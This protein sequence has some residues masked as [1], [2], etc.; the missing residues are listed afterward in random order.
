MEEDSVDRRYFE[1]LSP[2]LRDVFS[3]VFRQ[4]GVFFG[5]FLAVF[6]SVMLYTMFAPGYQAHM[7]VL[8][9]RG[10]ADPLMTPQA[11]A[12]TEFQRNDITEEELNSE[13]ELLRDEEMLR[14]VVEAT[15]L[16]ENNS[17]HIFQRDDQNVRVAHAVR[18]MGRHLKA[19]PIRKTNLIAVSYDSGDPALAARVLNNLAVAYVEKH[20]EVHRPSGEF[21]FFEQ[22]TVDYGRRLQEAEFQLLDFTRDQGVVSAALERDIALQ[23]L[24]EAEVNSLQLRLA[25]AETEHR[26][27]T[28]Q[29]DMPSIPERTTTQVRIADN[30]QLLEKLKS[31]LLE[32]QLNRTGL[33]TKY[34]PS[35]RL[36]Q[37]VEQQIA[38]TRQSIAAERLTP[39]REETTEKDLN[40]E[41]VRQ[42]TEKA[43]VELSGLRARA[44]LDERQLAHSRR[45]A[46][47]LGQDAITQQDLLRTM[48]AAEENYLLYVRKREEARIGDALDE[49]GILNVIVAEPPTVPALPKH[50]LLTVALAGVVL[51]GLLST[52]VSF[53]RDYLDPAFR[54]P[55]EV[56]ACLRTP[57]LASLPREVA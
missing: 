11:N 45:Q 38:E 54:T 18:R 47:Q 17:F 22:Q 35:Y 16:A 50:S 26:M 43:S 27:R 6:L 57:V 39:T 10:R 24:S 56:V 12:P 19:E 9:R 52:G 41:W 30:P 42:E 48:K 4:R 14:K 53:A 25:I 36:V 37:E 44:A 46:R 1:G 55:E 33:L 7:K 13:V 21:K 34:E 8:V 31:K 15:G 32:L 40:H 28:L 23:K 5:C 2:T 20:T 49:R 29:A 51:A 3:I